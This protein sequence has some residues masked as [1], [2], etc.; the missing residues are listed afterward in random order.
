MA[1]KAGINVNVSD[2]LQIAGAIKSGVG[3]QH[4]THIANATSAPVMVLLTH[5]KGGMNK[6]VIESRAYVG[7]PTAHGSVSAYAIKHRNGRFG[8]VADSQISDKSDRSFIVK[9]ASTGHLVFVHSKYGASV[10]TEDT[11]MRR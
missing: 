10:W 2:I 6:R 3:Q 7:F 8:M 11:E 1:T 4:N 9:E 5:S